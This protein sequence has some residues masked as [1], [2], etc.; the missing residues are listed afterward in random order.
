M[1]RFKR[2]LLYTLLLLLVLIGIF[3]I[4]NYPVSAA[5]K[6]L[7]ALS[8]TSDIRKNLELIIQ[9]AK[10]RNYKNIDVLDTVAERI[11]QEFSNYSGEVNM[12]NYQVNQS[13]YK[14]VIAS[15]GPQ[16]AERIIIGAHYDVCGE[17]DGADDNASGV[18]G[19]LQLAKLLK[20]KKLKYRIDLVAYT[21]EEPPFF[22][23]EQMGSYVHA[24]SLQEDSV[25][26]KGM[27]SLEMIGY[28][29]DE[30]G[31]Q[32]Y[33]LGI[34]KWVYGNKGNFITIAQNSFC[35]DFAKQFKTLYFKNNSIIAKS[36]RAPSFLG[37]IGLSD[38][39]NYWKFGYS[40]VM[41]TNTAFFRDHNYHKR[42]DVLK[43]L[44]LARMGQVID[45]VYRTVTQ[46]E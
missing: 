37:G 10:P 39:S 33:P 28:Y 2:I 22:N 36:F 18:A 44:D 17:Q 34:L 15:F 6:N 7:P 12:Q 20:D 25:P 26:V 11:R 13:W 38:H 24:K 1:K 21:L 19:I 32:D 14:N 43:N 3:A 31:S 9:T 30:A 23:T 42:T 4:Q 46:M 45:G 27:I 35:G 16:G 41:I 29:S 5:A 40:A 8:D